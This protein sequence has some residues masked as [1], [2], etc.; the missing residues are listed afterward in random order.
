MATVNLHTGVLTSPKFAPLSDGALRLWLHGLCWCKEHLTDG[1]IPANMVPTLHRQAKKFVGEL[2]VSHVPGKQALWQQ[3]EGGYRVH[4]YADWQD[5]ADAVQERR[6]K[7]RDAKRGV[8]KPSKRDSASETLV[9]SAP[10]STPDSTSESEKDSREGSG[11]G[12]GSGGG[13]ARNPSLTDDDD[14]ALRESRTPATG[15]SAVVVPWTDSLTSGQL[16]QAVVELLAL[17][18]QFGPP[19]AIVPVFERLQPRT[20]RDLADALRRRSLDEW[21]A[22]FAACRERDYLAG[23]L[24]DAPIT[25]FKALELADRIEAGEYRNHEAS[26]PTGGGLAPG[27]TPP[28]AERREL[29]AAGPVYVPPAARVGGAS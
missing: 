29:V 21:Q 9:E 12:G 22:V 13:T 6:R 27:W 14:Q 16:R 10:R 28:T 4:D 11:S 18:R 17:W 3:V 15:T 2:L 1:F 26:V 24:G 8:S 20:K 23:R 25:L 7:W 5:S 19:G